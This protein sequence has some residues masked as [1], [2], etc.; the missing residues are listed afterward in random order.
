MKIPDSELTPQQLR[1]KRMQIVHQQSAE[2]R[3]VRKEEKAK[4]KE[5]MNKLKEENP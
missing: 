3:L 2:L 1:V 5:E 4:K